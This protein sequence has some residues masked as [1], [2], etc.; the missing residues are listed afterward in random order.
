MAQMK[1]N[2]LF[3]SV[4]E[5]LAQKSIANREVFKSRAYNKAKET[6]MNISGAILKIEDIQSL[7]GIGKSIFERLEK[8]MLEHNLREKDTTTVI[9]QEYKKDVIL[10]ASDILTGVYGIGPVK[11]AQ[12]IECGITT[13]EKLRE[14]QFE[15]LNEKQIIGLKHYED[16]LR[17]IPRSEI[18]QYNNLLKR[19]L[20]DTLKKNKISASSGTK[21][22]IV[23]SYR[24]GAADSGDID[25][26][27]TSSSPSV[28]I[29]WIDRLIKDKVILDVL[30]RGPSK[31]L[32]MA[33]IPDSNVVRRVDFLYSPPDEFAFA[34]LYF[35]GSKEFNTVMRSRALKFG[36]TLNEHGFH[37]MVDSGN[38]NRK[39]KGDK[40]A[41][42]FEDE[43]AIF[44]A[45]NMVWKEPHER[46]D[47]ASVVSI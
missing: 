32:V 46:K 34:I 5:D 9:S 19:S 15:V 11:A 47:G 8:A 10:N 42:L 41:K 18:D 36:F 35:T 20:E 31:C 38:N 3:I 29:K 2:K 30:S 14:V 45:L 23:G 21:Y 44:E 4:L 6:I 13:I 7:P 33:K 25:I 17:R 37:Q 24:R 43:K 26:I 1:Y 39:V 40:V 27:V 16:V 22:E 28:F 12:L